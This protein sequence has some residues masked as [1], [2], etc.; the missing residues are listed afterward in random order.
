MARRQVEL[1]RGRDLVE[2][3]KALTRSAELKGERVIVHQ[4]ITTEFVTKEAMDRVPWYLD[5]GYPR[6]VIGD[7]VEVWIESDD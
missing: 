4:S 7:K 3:W 6:T 1:P 5:H 2:W